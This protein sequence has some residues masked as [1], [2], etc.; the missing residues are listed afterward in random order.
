MNFMLEGC[1]IA[2]A[3]GLW[4]LKAEVYVQ[5]QVS[6]CGICGGQ[7]GTRTSFSPSTSVF[8]CQYHSTDDPYPFLSTFSSYQQDKE[9]QSLG[10]FKSKA[11]LFIGEHWIGEYFHFFQARKC[12][13]SPLSSLHSPPYGYLQA[14]G[15]SSRVQL[16][17]LNQN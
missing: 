13:V 1:A 3:V 8:T 16:P 9:R 12:H 6:P 2:Q 15:R 4:P 7:Y 10:T 5:S 14:G 11:L 17:D